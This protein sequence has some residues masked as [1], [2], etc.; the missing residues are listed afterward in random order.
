[1]WKY[2]THCR[3]SVSPPLQSMLE[4]SQE[5]LV[6]IFGFCLWSVTVSGNCPLKEAPLNFCTSLLKKPLH[7]LSQGSSTL[8]IR[9]VSWIMLW[10]KDVCFFVGTCGQLG[11]KSRKPWGDQA[12]QGSQRRQKG[13]QEGRRVMHLHG[14]QRAAETCSPF[15][16][17]RLFF[18]TWFTLM[19][20]P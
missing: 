1:M 15:C 20:P 2:S 12:E 19:F 3:C 8:K 11:E 6:P 17:H 4:F 14:H 18:K 10:T 7:I 5:S 16:L 13:G 9:T